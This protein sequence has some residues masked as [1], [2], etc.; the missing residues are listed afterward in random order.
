MG[1]V[2]TLATFQKA[3]LQNLRKQSIYRWEQLFPPLD[4][5]HC[6]TFFLCVFTCRLVLCMQKSGGVEFREQSD[7]NTYRAQPPLVN[8]TWV[9]VG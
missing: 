8:L 7:L 5:H 6:T 9:E 3:P 4:F 1:N 2:C